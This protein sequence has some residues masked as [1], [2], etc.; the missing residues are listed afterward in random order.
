MQIWVI[1]ETTHN[2][3]LNVDIASVVAYC[4]LD[5]AKAAAIK[6]RD[7]N[8]RCSYVIRLITLFNEI[9]QED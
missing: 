4:T 2:S 3:D 9:S 6:L 8:N 5:D 1:E 7:A